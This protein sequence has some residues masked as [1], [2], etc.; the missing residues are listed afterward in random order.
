[1]DSLAGYG[2]VDVDEASWQQAITDY[3]DHQKLARQLSDKYNDSRASVKAAEGRLA[4]LTGR[5]KDLTVVVESLSVN[6]DQVVAARQKLEADREAMA[7][8]A[9]AKATAA[10]IEKA[11]KDAAEAHKAWQVRWSR[12]NRWRTLSSR[13][14]KMRES[15]F[16]HNGLSRLVALSNLRGLEKQLNSSLELFGNP[17]SVQATEDLSFMVRFPGAPPRRAERLS[18]GLKGVLAA[19]FRP[20]LCSLFGADLGFLTLD[21][22]TEFLDADNVAYL[23]AALENWA[24]RIRGSRQVL[25][26]THA[27]GLRNC[28]DQTIDLARQ[29]AADEG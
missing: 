21:E 1:M 27:Q 29:E 11:V 19:A 25:V 24:V 22:P 2:S 10:A 6:E 9:A 18:G 16:H 17:F 5:V 4:L 8:E 12:G 28:F 14:T 15:V 20:A 26:I 3:Q 13:L 23:A 7:D